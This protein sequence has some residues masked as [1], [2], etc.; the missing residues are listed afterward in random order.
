MDAQEQAIRDQIALYRGV[1][2]LNLMKA[3]SLTMIGVLLL[4]MAV[5]GSL[6][7][8]GGLPASATLG[9]VLGERGVTVVAIGIG[10]VIIAGGGLWVYRLLRD[11][12]VNVKQYEAELRG[13]PSVNQ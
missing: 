11:L 2:S 12:W 5:T 6:F 1:R 8:A 9:R 13:S 7:P 3:L 4:D 10:L